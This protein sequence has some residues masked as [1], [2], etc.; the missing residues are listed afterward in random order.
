MLRLG[1]RRVLWGALLLTCPAAA[2]STARFDDVARAPTGRAERAAAGPTD[3]WATRRARDFV[4]R[5]QLHTRRGDVAL[6]LQAY[7]EAIRV[8]GSHGPAYL[9][10]AWLR[11]GLGDFAEAERLY[12][13]AARLADIAPE[14][15]ARRAR[16]RSKL[17]R[18]LDA[19]RDLE[20]SVRLDPE[21]PARARELAS[22]YSERQAWP[23]ALALWRRL[24]AGA[25]K[26]NNPGEIAAARIQ[27]HA[28]S[29]LAAESDPVV[30]AARAHPN[31][32]RRSIR[33][34]AQRSV[35]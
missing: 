1:S 24:L 16:L 18:E 5:A 29:L 21:S 27:V 6:A 12:E 25:E 3:S 33:S 15:Y 14:A 26:D 31:W 8:D 10:L 9:G 11:E 20:A 30:G 4:E 13:A 28:L 2:Q 35:R 23:A 17:G 19:L 32:V 7:S 34:A 22:W